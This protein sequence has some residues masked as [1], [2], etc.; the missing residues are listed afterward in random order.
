M[1]VISPLQIG[2][3]HRMHCAIA[4]ITCATIFFC[5]LAI[6]SDDAWF[7]PEILGSASYVWL[8]PGSESFID[9]LRKVFDWKAFDPNVNRVRPLNDFFETV[10]AI[11]RPYIALL[12]GPRLSLNFSSALS[13]VAAP[14]H[15]NFFVINLFI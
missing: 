3:Q 9:M 12:F 6:W 5:Y 1:Q 15:C 2:R 4:S 11:A 8:R 7:H 14:D 13:A 10:D